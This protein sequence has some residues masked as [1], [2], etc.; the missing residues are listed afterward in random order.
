MSPQ[1]ENCPSCGT[2]YLRDQIDCCLDCYQKNEAAYKQVDA[3]LKNPEHRN[4][5]AEDVHRFT[6][7]SMNRIAGFL[8]D[9][10]ILSAD[11]PNLSYPCGRC[12]KPIKRQMLCQACY[13]AFST[14]VKF[15]LSDSASTQTVDKRQSSNAQYWKLKK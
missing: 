3:F 2:L 10:R 5:S 15:V 1:L 14:E 4:A 6:G 9:G 13:R 12:K 8:R 7:V 11:Y